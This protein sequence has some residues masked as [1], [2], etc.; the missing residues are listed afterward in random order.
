MKLGKQEPELFMSLF[1]ESG[2]E[3]GLPKPS[4]KDIPEM[5]RIIFDEPLE[6]SG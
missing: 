5:M 3:L 4:E 1:I 2:I 6:D